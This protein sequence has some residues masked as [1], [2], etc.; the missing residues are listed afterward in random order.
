[1]RMIVRY[2]FMDSQGRKIYGLV[3]P[4]GFGWDSY[5]SY[6]GI[7]GDVRETWKERKY[8]WP[9]KLL[10][11]FICFNIWVYLFGVVFQRRYGACITGGMEASKEK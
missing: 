3:Y 4:A 7:S 2:I 9:I 10:L 1:M 11:G 8:R 6:S 5:G